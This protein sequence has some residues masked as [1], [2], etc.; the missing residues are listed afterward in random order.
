MSSSAWTAWRAA[1]AELAR[2]GDADAAAR[3]L[4]ETQAWL[5]RATAAVEAGNRAALDELQATAPAFELEVLA[6]LALS[7]PGDIDP[8][9]LRAALK[10][11][12]VRNAP[13][14]RLD[15]VR[16][17][18]VAHNA[19]PPTRPPSLAKAA[20]TRPVLAAALEVLS[21]RFRPKTEPDDLLAR[22]R[23]L[24][25]F[26]AA[27]ALQH[28]ATGDVRGAVR[29]SRT[30][31]EPLPQERWPDLDDPLR[32]APR[33]GT[34]VSLA[35]FLRDPLAETW[36]PAC[37]RQA[38]TIRT[39]GDRAQRLA[40]IG[41]LLD[42]IDVL[43]REARPRA[44]IPVVQA[45]VEL[46]EASPEIRRREVLLNQL[47]LLELRLRWSSP[48]AFSDDVGEIV[49]SALHD[50]SP[51]DRARFAR[52]IL[53]RTDEPPRSRRVRTEL[54][55]SAVQ[56]K[57]DWER[58]ILPALE[59]L[60]SDV[61][62]RAFQRALRDAPARERDLALGYMQSLHG[63]L[64]ET[65]RLAA[66]AIELGAGADATRMVMVALARVGRAPV[67]RRQER[68]LRERALLEVARAADACAAPPD[69]FFLLALFAILATLPEHARRGELVERLGSCATRRLALPT[70]PRHADLLER[71]QLMKMIGLDDRA[72][73]EFRDFGRWLRRADPDEAVPAALRMCAGLCPDEET[74]RSY[75][76]IEDGSEAAGD[77]RP[78]WVRAVTAWLDRQS[79]EVVGRHALALA[80]S[81]SA[82][83]EGLDT[84]FREV[85]D[86]EPCEAWDALAEMCMPEIPIEFDGLLQELVEQFGD[87]F[88][89]WED[90]Y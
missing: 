46:T 81:D 57:A 20:R 26:W 61:D 70:A 24:A 2:T 64:V 90:P 33:R 41:G 69:A 80:R 71:L 32:T 84:W 34:Q 78:A 53:E 88:D 54:L 66:R 9:R 12:G 36:S 63:S 75:G 31:I 60:G 43:V 30:G 23:R 56:S 48:E 27:G 49:W 11:A 42:A 58:E 68:R 13:L 8:T 73:A 83:P 65:L 39:R 77:L 89:P 16:L 79:T 62:L 25:S 15:L 38:A 74:I 50:R 19:E 51:E 67:R 37:E 59:V 18:C 7:D 52:I 10:Q 28:E 55:A 35:D 76:L 3:D 40:A 47:T 21:D 72:Q 1:E 44:A 17:A 29:D 85:S 45:A 86:L 4:P 5:L 87:D 22:S 6:E 14:P 82:N